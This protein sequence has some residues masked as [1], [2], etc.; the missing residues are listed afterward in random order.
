MGGTELEY[1]RTLQ[2]RRLAVLGLF[3]ASLLAWFAFNGWALSPVWT[4][5][6][7][8]EGDYF[9]GDP[10]GNWIY[11]TCD[12]E[13]QQISVMRGGR[14]EGA[15]GLDGPG[16]PRF[17]DWC[18]LPVVDNPDLEAWRAQHERL[19]MLAA[20]PASSAAQV[21]DVVRA[22]PV[23]VLFLKPVTDW[24]EADPAH[25]ADFLDVV[26]A[27]PVQFRHSNP[28]IVR[29]RQQYFNGLVEDALDAA[30]AAALAQPERV[31][32]WLAQPQIAGSRAALRKLAAIGGL[33]EGAR[34]KI[35][36]D[37]DSLPP[38]ERADVYTSLAPDLVGRDDY[39]ALL[40]RQL[41]LLPP[42][43]QTA[44]VHRLLA[45][46]EASRQFSIALLAEFGRRFA[47]GNPEF[48]LETFMSIADRLKNEAEAPLLLT[49][50][51][52]DLPDPQRRLAATYLLSLDDPGETAFALGVLHSLG[53]LHPVSRPPVVHA[54]LQS[55]QFDDRAVQQAC[56][57]AIRMETQGEV[58]QELL[59]A[60][61]RHHRLDEELHSR[62]Q[63]ELG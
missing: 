2:R 10:F 62:I 6:E 12:G 1:R 58:R 27:Q 3:I 52:R 5:F 23:S 28:I 34:A 53:D 4:F 49:R 22:M 46:P 59:D 44:A 40:T 38:Q 8:D 35:L 33:S 25:A 15:Q 7:N 29:T 31:E 51:L 37:L 18:G 32:R 30:T 11:A 20:S 50:H 48:Q 42:Q 61:L 17:P 24:L 36:G 55:A 13:V 43:A 14:L 16:A 56:L 26:A 54:A 9:A 45:R 19:Q 60:M 47:R 57:L 41:R 39:A 21:L 63:A